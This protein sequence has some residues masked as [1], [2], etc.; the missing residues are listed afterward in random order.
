MNKKYAVNLVISV[1]I[2]LH[3]NKVICPCFSAQIPP[4]VDIKRTEK[5]DKRTKFPINGLLG[6]RF[7]RSSPLVSPCGEI[8]ANFSKF[9]EFFIDPFRGTSACLKIITYAM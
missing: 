4:E 1:A 3:A 9:R 8:F 5:S 7:A 2:C 6:V